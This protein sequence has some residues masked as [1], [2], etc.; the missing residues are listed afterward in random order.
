MSG[1][2][3]GLRIL[4]ILTRFSE[5]SGKISEIPLKL[6]ISHSFTE[7]EQNSIILIFFEYLDYIIRSNRLISQ[8][9]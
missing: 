3:G 9:D 2:A 7:Y 8:I 5:L 4:I 1:E 6:M